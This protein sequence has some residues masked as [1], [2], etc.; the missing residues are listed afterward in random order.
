MESN[1]DGNPP[2]YHTIYIGRSTATLLNFP[3]VDFGGIYDIPQLI[4][5]STLYFGGTNLVDPKNP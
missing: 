2:H 3:I 5:C 4:N 1:F